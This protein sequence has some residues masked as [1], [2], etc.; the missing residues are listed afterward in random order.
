MQGEY[1][2]KGWG[3]EVGGRA[4]HSKKQPHLAHSEQA[5]AEVEP[6]EV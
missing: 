1:L 3:Q 6:G 2:S 5:A 4:L